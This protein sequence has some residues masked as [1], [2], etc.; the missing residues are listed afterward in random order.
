MSNFT[1]TQEQLAGHTVAGQ[2]KQ[3]KVG[4]CA[5][6][7]VRGVRDTAGGTHFGERVARQARALEELDSIAPSELAVRVW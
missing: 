1:A 5:H 6:L 4:P 7:Y 2:S 3:H